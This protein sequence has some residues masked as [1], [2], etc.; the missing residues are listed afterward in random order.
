M[1]KL[2]IEKQ[3]MSL[4]ERSFYLK[5]GEQ[6]YVIQVCQ[7]YKTRQRLWKCPKLKETKESSQLNAIHDLK[8]D[9]VPQR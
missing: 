3:Q 2:I 1:Y 6:D 5:E 9:S 7:C 4:N 8:L